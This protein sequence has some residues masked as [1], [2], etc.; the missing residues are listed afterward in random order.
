MTCQ[1]NS[2]KFM[3]SW[4]LCPC[5]RTRLKKKV[6]TTITPHQRENSGGLPNR[7][8]CN[9]SSLGQTVTN[10]NWLGWILG[11]F[12]CGWI[13]SWYSHRS[14][15]SQQLC[16]ESK[17]DSLPNNWFFYSVPGLRLTGKQNYVWQDQQLFQHHLVWK[18]ADL[19]PSST[20]RENAMRNNRL[21]T[22]INLAC[23]DHPSFEKKAPRILAEI[24]ASRVAPR[25]I[26][27][28]HKLGRE[29]HSE[30]CFEN[31]PK[32]RELLRGMAFSLR[33][34]FFSKF[35]WF[36]GFRINYVGIKYEI[37]L[38]TNVCFLVLRLLGIRHFQPLSRNKAGTT[39]HFQAKS[40]TFRNFQTEW[41]AWF[42]C[43][44]M[45]SHDSAW[46][47][48]IWLGLKNQEA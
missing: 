43:S 39:R 13:R 24:L 42:A 26:G 47:P 45:I 35:W 5:D 30:S 7:M 11:G 17:R 28:S 33:E 8:Q 16:Y 40:G 27:F 37:S 9:L 46:F 20:N 23:G 10:T 14:S 22:D 32:F 31:T 2:G 29:S 18:F 21:P 34:L 25:G 15:M 48:M 1:D 12:R 41:G 19:R 4:S 38:K 6:M 44:A 3:I 36:P